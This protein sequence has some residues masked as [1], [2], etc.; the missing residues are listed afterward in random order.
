MRDDLIYLAPRAESAF[1]R[2]YTAIALRWVPWFR[3]HPSDQLGYDPRTTVLLDDEAAEAFFTRLTI[4]TGLVMLI[5]P[6]WIL[7]F[8][9]DPLHRLGVITAFIL[10]FF[11]LL[12]FATT[13]RP[14][15]SLAGA[16]A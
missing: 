9:I 1:R 15:E 16:A 11:A 6:L 7:E 14:F 8:V 12:A 3:R 5:S 13:A 2:L 10:L 4:L